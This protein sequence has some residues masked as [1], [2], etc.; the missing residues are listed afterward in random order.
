MPSC[1]RGEGEEQAFV[2]LVSRYQVSLMRLARNY[3]RALSWQNV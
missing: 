2:E 1:S 3:A